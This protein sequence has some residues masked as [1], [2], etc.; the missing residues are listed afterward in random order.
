MGCCGEHWEALGEKRAVG[1]GGQWE[2]AG[3][4]LSHL[5]YAPHPELLS[6]PPSP[7]A[8]P[9]ALCPLPP[10][11]PP[12]LTLRSLQGRGRGGGGTLPL[13]AS[14]PPPGTPKPLMQAEFRIQCLGWGFPGAPPPRCVPPPAVL[15]A[16]APTYFPPT[17]SGSRETPQSRCSSG[18]APTHPDCVHQLTPVCPPRASVSPLPTGSSWTRTPS[19]NLTHVSGAGGVSGG[20]GGPAL[21]STT[22]VPSVCPL[23][24]GTGHQ[25]VAGGEC[26]PRAAANSMSGCHPASQTARWVAVQS[27]RWGTAQRTNQHVGGPGSRPT[28]VLGRRA[29]GQSARPASPS[30]AAPLPPPAACPVISGWL[31]VG[32]GL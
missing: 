19:P 25:A 6:M 22:S 14:I 8:S 26:R 3:R 20:R 29:G 24:P 13:S 11:A 5:P 21:S 17:P 2:V 1:L 18:C 9:P 27:A 31:I 28:R 15:P 7:L 32:L 30:F 4:G 23:H 10:G 12:M 16:A